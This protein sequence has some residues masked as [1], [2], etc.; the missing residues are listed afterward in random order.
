MSL[1]AHGW[2]KNVTRTRTYGLPVVVARKYRTWVIDMVGAGE[3]LCV[4]A[5]KSPAAHL[6]L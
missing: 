3:E 6:G 4:V 5:V 2:R 1:V